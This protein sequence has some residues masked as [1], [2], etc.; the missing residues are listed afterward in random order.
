MGSAASLEMDKKLKNKKLIFNKDWL[1]ACLSWREKYPVC[2]PEY[3]KL[4]KKINIYYFIEALS[5]KLT[6]RDAVVTDAG[7]AFFVGSQGIKVKQGLRYIASG[8]FA[9]MGYSLPASIG[10]S[11]ALGRKRV[12]CI[13]GDGSFQQNIQITE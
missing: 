3:K 1:K 2:L 10:V 7:S 8:G 5:K 13:T 6:S 4:K 12:M 11:V 9:T